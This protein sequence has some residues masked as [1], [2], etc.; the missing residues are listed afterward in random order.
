LE[1]EESRYSTISD[2]HISV[3]YIYRQSPIYT[4]PCVKRQGGATRKAEPQY[5]FV[6]EIITETTREDVEIS[7]SGSEKSG[8][9]REGDKPDEESSEKN[10]TPQEAEDIEEPAVE[11]GDEHSP[12]IEKEKEDEPVKITPVDSEVQKDAD[13]E[14]TQDSKEKAIDEQD[15]Y[16][17][18]DTKHTEQKDL[19]N[20]KVDGPK[21]ECVKKTDKPAKET[22]KDVPKPDML[23][24]QQIPLKSETGS[25]DKPSQEPQS[26]EATTEVNAKP[27]GQTVEVTSPRTEDDTHKD[28]KISPEKEKETTPVQSVEE[29][30]PKPDKPAAAEP[31]ESGKQTTGEDTKDISDAVQ[32]EPLG[33]DQEDNNK[34]TEK[35]VEKKQEAQSKTEEKEQK[36]EEF[37]KDSKVVELVDNVKTKKG[38]SIKPKETEKT[39]EN[40]SKAAEEKSQPEKSKEQ[41]LAKPKET[42]KT[43]KDI[44]KEKSQPE[45]S[46]IQE[47][48]KSD[49]SVE[50][51][52]SGG[53]VKVT[54]KQVDE[55]LSNQSP[56]AKETKSDAKPEQ[57]DTKENK[58][59]EK[60]EEE[61]SVMTNGSGTSK[62]VKS[63]ETVSKHKESDSEHEVK[64]TKTRDKALE[65]TE[66]VKES[67]TKD[68]VDTKGPEET[69]KPTNVV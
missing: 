11:N 5:K 31:A 15:K 6:E 50:S 36:P 24:K 55:T 18:T 30:S 38:E 35:H 27:S 28:A 51:V 34:L 2:A 65:K 17:E 54:E 14:P 40:L 44:S 4:L 33:K 61:D 62:D 69:T 64:P 1:G 13:S 20:G 53:E 48:S 43:Q 29:D 16:E 59:F 57:K 41:E 49:S 8:E 21:E 39:Q 58:T 60:A 45:K 10:E 42:E 63:E 37:V 67:S 52:T 9:G 19:L 23:E 22:E 32:S 66:Q 46:Q 12:E 25:K 68:S 7:D 56:K 3:P 26:P 47:D